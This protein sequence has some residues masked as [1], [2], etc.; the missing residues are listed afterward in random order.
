MDRYFAASFIH[1]DNIVN[2]FYVQFGINPL[3]KHIISNVQDIHIARP[4]PIAK[5]RAFY[6]LRSCQKRK[7]RAGHAGSS[8]IMRMH[9]QN[10]TFPVLKMSVHPFDLI[11]IHVRRR[12]LH[13]RG[14]INDN[15][16]LFVSPPCFLNGSTYL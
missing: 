8:V 15:G 11:R 7:L 13:S 1:F 10:N 5:Q 9:A 6:P 16:I 3:G 14:Q 2:F 12:H 4:L